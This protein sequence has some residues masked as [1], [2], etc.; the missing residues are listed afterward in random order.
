M[1]LT[2][3]RDSTFAST[4]AGLPAV[5]ATDFLVVTGAFDCT[6]TGVAFFDTGFAFTFAIGAAF[7]AAVVEGLFVFTFAE[8]SLLATGA[9]VA[10]FFAT[11]VF[12]AGFATCF[13]AGFADFVATFFAAS[14]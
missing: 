3:G 14:V 5:F 1:T 4:G 8:A 11:A 9:L 7:F 2:P 10:V 12:T 13:A 6:D